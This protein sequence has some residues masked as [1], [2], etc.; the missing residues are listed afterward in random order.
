MTTNANEEQPTPKA[1]DRAPIWPMVIEYVKKNYADADGK[2]PVINL[3]NDMAERHEIGIK[4]Y[5]VSLTSGNGRNSM[6]D[7]YQ[8]LLDFVVYVR[9]WL[10]EREISMIAPQLAVK[11]LSAFGLPDLDTS[12]L[13]EM[14]ARSVELDRAERVMA[15]LF[16]AAIEALL[17]MRGM[18][19]ELRE[20]C[21]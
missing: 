7:A 18:L 4:R 15:N 2:T 16:S 14:V 8:E 6:V 10:D 19:D 11:G 13:A 9:T 5:G 12:K 3:V 20:A 1:T 21:K 17:E